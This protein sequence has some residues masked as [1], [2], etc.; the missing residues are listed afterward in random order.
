VPSDG[1]FLDEIFSSVWVVV[2]GF[3]E[4]VGGT[5]ALQDMFAACGLHA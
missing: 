3:G 1:G 4:S 5:I 2:V